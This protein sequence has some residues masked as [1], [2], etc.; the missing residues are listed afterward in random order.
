M[1]FAKPVDDAARHS[2]VG[3]LGEV[4]GADDGVVVSIALV[5]GVVACLTD[6]QVKDGVSLLCEI[7]NSDLRY[8]SV[9]ILTSRLI[10]YY[11]SNRSCFTAQGALSGKYR[12]R[13]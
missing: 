1:K 2:T 10:E 3:V 11:V 5:F 8:L 6:L 9:I 7:Q 4:V 13:H 12:S